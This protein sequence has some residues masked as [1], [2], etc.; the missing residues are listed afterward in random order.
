MDPQQSPCKGPPCIPTERTMAGERRALPS[1]PRP[2]A[3]LRECVASGVHQ[4]RPAPSTH[5]CPPRARWACSCWPC[6]APGS[7]LC[8]SSPCLV[9]KSRAVS[10][11]GSAVTTSDSG[12]SAALVT[13]ISVVHALLWGTSCG[14]QCSRRHGSHTSLSLWAC[15]H[16]PGPE[17]MGGDGAEREGMSHVRTHGHARSGAGHQE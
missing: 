14:T 13:S 1:V 4:P 12:S 6:P 10:P 2:A 11:A 5:S 7:C 8:G 15:D 9:L 3:A 17:A 16:Q